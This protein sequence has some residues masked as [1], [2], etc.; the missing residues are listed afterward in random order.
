M[1]LKAG[2][3]SEPGYPASVM[4]RSKP[5]RASNGAK[6][7]RPATREWSVRPGVRFGSRQSEASGSSGRGRSWQSAGPRGRPRPSG[8]RRGL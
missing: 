1:A 6:R 5:S 7:K 2:T 3:I 4:R 8:R